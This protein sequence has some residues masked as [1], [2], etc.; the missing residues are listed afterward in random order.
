MCAVELV[1]NKSTKQSFPTSK[2]VGLQVQ[3]KALEH[4]LVSRVKGDSFLLAPP[5]VIS[6]AQLEQTVNILSQAI[7]D[8]TS[9]L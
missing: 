7:V 3:R 6:D 2:A 9:S 4:G 8:V 5:I 1:E